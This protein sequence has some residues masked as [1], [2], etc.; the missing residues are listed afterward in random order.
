MNDEDR[1]ELMRALAA[2][3]AERVEHADR[4]TARA[5]H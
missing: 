3:V 4:P 1:I 5:H 2:F